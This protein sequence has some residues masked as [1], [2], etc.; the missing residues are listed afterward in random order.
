MKLAAPWLESLANDEEAGQGLRRTALTSI[1]SHHDD[2]VFPQSGARLDGAEN[3]AIGGC[4]HVALL[5]DR[6]VR[7]IVFDRLT[8]VAT[9]AATTPP[10]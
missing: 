5:Y 3:I 4:G 6:R 10:S 9:Q 2:I 8:A 7:T 1:Y